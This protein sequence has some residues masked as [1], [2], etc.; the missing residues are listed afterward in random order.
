MFK[1][2]IIVLGISVLLVSCAGKPY[3]NYK[4]NQMIG[5]VHTVN[6]ESGYVEVD[7][8]EWHKRD[9]RGDVDDYGVSLPI[10]AA[11]GLVL[12]HEDG[13][14]AEIDQLR[15]GQKVLVNP[16][17][18]DKDDPYQAEEI[19]LLE[20]TFEER[21]EDLISRRKGQY[22]TTVMEGNGDDITPEMKEKLMGLV[23]I[24]PLSFGGEFPKNHVAD[25]EKELEIDQY[26]VMLVFD[27]KGLV[28]K[29]YDVD[30]L[31]DFLNL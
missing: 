31:I 11:D 15:I 12:K 6:S 1:K 9:V 16:P 7:I 8:S 10:E 21:F 14:P 17:I 2:T 30:E 22:Y 13:S 19:V 3:G 26:P 20:M 24:S 18:R 5:T 4:D 27:H 23:S 25:Y 28:F 29:T